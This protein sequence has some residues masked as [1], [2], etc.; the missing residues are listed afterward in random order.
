MKVLGIDIGGSAFKAAPVDTKTGKLLAERFRVPI[1]NPCSRAEG[2]A[3]AKQ[4]AAHFKWKGRIGVGFPG[5]VHDG[6]ISLVGNLGPEWEFQN[7]SRIFSRATG[8]AVSVANDA[9]VAG[10]AEMRF[11]AGQGREGTVL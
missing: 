5:I 10:V 1:S 3:A 8:C 2:L 7:G 11:G 9:D 6:R 4:I